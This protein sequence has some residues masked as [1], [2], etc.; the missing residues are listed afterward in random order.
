MKKVNS[1]TIT[2][3]LAL[4]GIMVE[5]LAFGVGHMS[6]VVATRMRQQ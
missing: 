4:N 1:K 6:K 5:E 2:K 3:L